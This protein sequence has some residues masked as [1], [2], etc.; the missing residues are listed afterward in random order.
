M[1]SQDEKVK[2]VTH[3]NQPDINEKIKTT[4]TVHGEFENH[5]KA[6]QYAYEHLNTRIPAGKTVHKDK[7]SYFGE[8]GM[9]ILPAKKSIKEHESHYWGNGKGNPK[10]DTK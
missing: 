2:L 7:D 3:G 6:R 1:K 4:P 5:E 10:G 8:A 9:T